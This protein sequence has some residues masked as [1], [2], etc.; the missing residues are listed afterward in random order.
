MQGF[1]K[2][3]S[4]QVKLADIQYLLAKENGFN[5]WTEL[6]NSIRSL[7]L[8][9]VIKAIQNGIP[10][11]PFDDEARENEGDFVIAAEKVNH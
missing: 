5:S 9:G 2:V 11:I 3:D 6:K 4:K 1:K 10:I 8:D 7:K